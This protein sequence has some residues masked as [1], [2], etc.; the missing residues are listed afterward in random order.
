MC[1]LVFIRF[2]L[3]YFYILFQW[4]Q[5]FFNNVC[6]ALTIRKMFNT[7]AALMILTYFFCVACVLCSRYRAV[8]FK[9]VPRYSVLYSLALAISHYC[10]F[11]RTYVELLRFNGSC[12]RA[13]LSEFYPQYTLFILVY[14]LQYYLM[15]CFILVDFTLYTVIGIGINGS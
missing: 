10:L 13:K 5:L 3:D 8:C 2:F 7:S 1:I 4:L 6:D 12:A 9:A 11:L 15:N 14:R